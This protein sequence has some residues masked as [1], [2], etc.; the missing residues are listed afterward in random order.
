MPYEGFFITAFSDRSKFIHHALQEE[1]RTR[2]VSLDKLDTVRYDDTKSSKA[3][4]PL[5]LLAKLSRRLT[6]SDFVVVDVS[7]PDGSGTF[8]PN[9]MFELGRAQE[10]RRPTFS[11]CDARLLQS[12]GA[13][14]FDIAALAQVTYE[15]SPE[16]LRALA[17][18][19]G[20]W[21]DGGILTRHALAQKHFR[22]LVRLREHFTSWKEST[23]HLFG[24]V[25]DVVMGRLNEYTGAIAKANDGATVTLAFRPLRR[26]DMIQA[27]FCATLD[28]MNETDEYDTV[29]TLEFW[30][31]IEGDG[32]TESAHNVDTLLKATQESLKRRVKNRRLFLVPGW[33][34]ASVRPSEALIEG[35]E[36]LAAQYGDRYTLGYYVVDDPAEYKKLKER[37]HVGVCRI[38]SRHVDFV[39]QPSYTARKGDVSDRLIALNYVLGTA[40]ADTMAQ[41]I[42]RLWESKNS[43]GKKRASC[44]AEVIENK[45]D[46]PDG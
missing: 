46:L 35:H 23:L 11:I 12:R 24:P 20:Q 33:D 5:D 14:P 29:S 31:E 42:D 4:D 8:N 21:L 15:F 6:E 39:L 16:G 1:A 25:I 17:L 2:S 40:K 37:Y 9:V 3:D 18:R 32:D 13:L 45:R 22:D 41:A 19:F 36:A 26:Q 27:V 30:R 44:W 7:P 10:L 43:Q 38:R 28:A 34:L